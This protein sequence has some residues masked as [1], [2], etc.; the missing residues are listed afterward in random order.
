MRNAQGIPIRNRILITLG[1][2]LLVVGW[3]LPAAATPGPRKL[4]VPED[5]NPPSGGGFGMPGIDLRSP[6]EIA[7]TGVLVNASKRTGNQS[8]TTIGINPTN[9][10]NVVLFS[11]EGSA[12]AIFHAYSFDGGVTWT[13]G[14]IL[15]GACCDGQCVF[16]SFGNLFFVYIPG[17]V[18]SVV[19]VMSTDGGVTFGS[20]ITVGTGSID[21]PSIAVGNGSLWVDW[22]LNGNMVVRGAPVT[23]LGQLGAFGAQENVPG[24]GGSF[25]G[26]AVGPGPNG[27]KVMI[28]YENPYGDQGP[29]NI[30]VNVDPDGLGPQGF[31]PQVLATSTNVGG[32]DYIPAQPNRSI[33]AECSVAWDATGGQYNDRAYLLYTDE[34]VNE[35]NDTD[36]EVRVSNDEGATWGPPHRVND[37]PGLPLIRSQFLPFFSL[38]PTTGVVAAGWH[39]CR[40]DN[41]V[42]GTGGTNN[43]PNDDAEYFCSFTA[44]GGNTWAANV[45]LTGGF[46]N[47]TDAHNGIDYGDFVGTVAY[48][49]VFRAA[50]ADNSNSTGDNP[51]GTLH[52]FDIYTNSMPL[53]DPSSG[54]RPTPG[55]PLRIA[56]HPTLQPPMPNPASGAVSLAY[57]LPATEHALLTVHDISGREVARLTDGVSTSGRHTLNWDGHSADGSRLPAGVYFVRL[58]AGGERQ[59]QQ[60]VILK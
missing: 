25:G 58:T 50:W 44:D 56:A 30:Y 23:G 57:L 46:S 14:D 59:V 41:G 35:N 15:S 53:L 52:Q 29:A 18:S 38:D 20:P 4:V 13:G 36:I 31:G 26:L 9:P 33:D 27:G 60:A 12:S 6:L 10:N 16:D 3:A 24:N 8:E 54:V 47:A 1:L 49:G 34:T 43:I 5:P 45:Q 7:Q 40:N 28:T 37:D 21:Q 17:S 22:N 11:N 42:P 39:D 51:N 55:A 2:A 48:G 19:V 32:F